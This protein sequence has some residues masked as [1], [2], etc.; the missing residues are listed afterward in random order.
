M[1]TSDV[2]WREA[3]L[4]APLEIKGGFISAPTRPGLGVEIDEAAAA[5]YPFKPEAEQRY[6][7]PD[8]SVADW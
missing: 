1:L 3:V 6:F 2:P 7:H 8:G 5:K 4:D